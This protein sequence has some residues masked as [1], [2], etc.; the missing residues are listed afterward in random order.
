MFQLEI[1]GEITFFK[2]IF[3]LEIQILLC[4]HK[5]TFSI[6]KISANENYISYCF[7]NAGKSLDFIFRSKD[8][9]F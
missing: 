2:N 9:E 3:R 8:K 7:Q 1:C 4:N 6:H 5:S